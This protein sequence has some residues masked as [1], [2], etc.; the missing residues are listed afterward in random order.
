MRVTCTSRVRDGGFRPPRAAAGTLSFP[1][2]FHPADKRVFFFA[3][4]AIRLQAGRSPD[5]LYRRSTLPLGKKISSAVGRLDYM[6]VRVIKGIAEPLAISGAS[7]LSSTT[8]ADGFVL[9]PP[10]SE[11]YPPGADVE[12][13][14]YD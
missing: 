13:F 4:R 3:A 1:P 7:M 2:Q 5:W 8:R 11:G 10:D 9:V 6:R 12:V 14:L